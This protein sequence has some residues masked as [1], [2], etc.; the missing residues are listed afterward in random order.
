WELLQELLQVLGPFEEATR[1]L[2]NTMGLLEEVKCNLYKTLCYYYPDP[3]PH[4]L[5]SALLDPRLKSLDY[6]NDTNKIA[7]KNF[8]KELYDDEKTTEVNQ[9]ESELNDNTH[10]LKK[11][12]SDEFI[13]TAN[14]LY[15]P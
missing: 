11:K 4:E 12:V 7:A 14:P 1:Y 10:N 13:V 8:L 3:T 15:K 9:N 2:V 6:M 5:I